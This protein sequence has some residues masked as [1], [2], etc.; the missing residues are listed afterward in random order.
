MS[1]GVMLGVWCKKGDNIR[2]FKIKIFKIFLLNGNV[3]Y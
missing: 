2:M 3:K 1:R